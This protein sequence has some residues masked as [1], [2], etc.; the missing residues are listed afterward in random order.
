MSSLSL[1]GLTKTYGDTPVVDGATLTVEE[2]EFVSLLGPSGCGKTTILR[3]VAGLLAPSGGSIRI[4]ERDVT[5]LATHKRRIGL[6]FQ[7]YA[8]FPHLTV[9]ENV[10]FGLKRQGASDIRSRVAE[11]LDMVQLGHVAERYPKALSGG[12]QQRIALARAL[13]PRPSLLLLDE[14]LSNLDA[15]LRDDM[16]IELKRLQRELGITSL[17]VTHDQ[18]E[19]LS[20]SDRICILAH[21]RIQQYAAPEEV[22][23][24]P[25]NGFVARFIGKPNALSGTLAG[26][27][28]D[29]GV[30]LA[31]QPTV[32]LPGSGPVEVVVRHSDVALSRAP[33]EGPN[34]FAGTVRL[35]AFV[36]ARIQYVVG[37]AGGPELIAEVDSNDPA[38]DLVVGDTVSVRIE[39]AA[40]YVSPKFAA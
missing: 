4:G 35:R 40:V 29:I 5:R 25:A 32:P 14:P 12:Q 10:A 39:P 16:Q 28:V 7:S 6:V 13:A 27:R 20:M 11:A 36:G 26:D 37:I 18:S 9:F 8:L 23:R 31:F 21:G 2:G 34:V 33:A 19:A 30:P 38:G 3:M 17:F 24:R 15:Q 22:Y 1:Q